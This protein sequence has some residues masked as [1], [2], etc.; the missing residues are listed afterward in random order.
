MLPVNQSQD[1][2]PQA[3]NS[4]NS[5]SISNEEC[6]VICTAIRKVVNLQYLMDHANPSNPV[7]P[8]F[9]MFRIVNS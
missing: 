1:T 8:K 2:A 9:P 4:Q 6:E 5:H 7:K 3:I